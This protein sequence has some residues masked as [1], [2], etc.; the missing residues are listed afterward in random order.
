MKDRRSVMKGKRLEKD[1]RNNKEKNMGEGVKWKE[2]GEEYTERR[3][4]GVVEVI[5][6]EIRQKM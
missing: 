1:K 6:D 2:E 4:D 5:R 3:V